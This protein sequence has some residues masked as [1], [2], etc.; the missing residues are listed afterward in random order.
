M[1]RQALCATC[2]VVRPGRTARG[3]IVRR[4]RGMACDMDVGA[5]SSAKEPVRGLRHEHTR[6]G[7]A[8]SRSVATYGGIRPGEPGHQPPL[9]CLTLAP[10]VSRGRLGHPDVLGAGERPLRLGRKDDRAE[11]RAAATPRLAEVYLLERRAEPAAERGG[12]REVE[13]SQRWESA[14]NGREPGEDALWCG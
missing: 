12:R 14:E 13:Q 10:R 2:D 7:R 11:G 1:Y 8:S 4:R 3:L 9:R 5:V 6:A